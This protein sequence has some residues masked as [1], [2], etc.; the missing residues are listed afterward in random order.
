MYELC[1][2]QTYQNRIRVVYVVHPAGAIR[3]EV[4][5]CTLIFKVS[6]GSS[7]FNIYQGQR[8]AMSAG[9]H[10]RRSCKQKI[11]ASCLKPWGDDRKSLHEQVFTASKTAA[12][13]SSLS[14]GLMGRET[15]S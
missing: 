2:K 10:L 13:S 12:A 8:P 5:F 6:E 4:K 11:C 1:T 3:D 14:T 9:K 15:T 7:S